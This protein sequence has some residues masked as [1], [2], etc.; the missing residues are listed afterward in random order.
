MVRKASSIFTLVFAVAATSI[1]APMAYA[2]NEDGDC[3]WTVT[4]LGRTICDGDCPDGE[5]CTKFKEDDA[6]VCECKEDN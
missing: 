4:P 1:V 2:E 6:D 5:T 3:G